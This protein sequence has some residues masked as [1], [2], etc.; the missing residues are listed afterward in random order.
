MN[1]SSPPIGARALRL[2]LALAVAACLLS[3]FC[4]SALG[5]PTTGQFSPAPKDSLK[6]VGENHSVIV[7]WRSA[8]PADSVLMY[9]LEYKEV[10]TDVE[11]SWKRIEIRD[12]SVTTWTVGGLTNYHRYA[13]HLRVQYTN[14]K[15]SP[16]SGTVFATP[17][18]ATLSDL[19]VNTRTVTGFSPYTLTY[20]VAFPLGTVQTPTVTATTNDPTATAVVTNAGSLPGSATVVVTA[21]AT[22][23][24]T[25]RRTYTVNFTLAPPVT[26]S[27]DS[28]G[29]E[30]LD[31]ITR[32]SG[33][34]L[35]ELAAPNKADSAFL[36]WYT[37]DDTFEHAVAEDTIVT[38]NLTLHA[39][40]AALAAAPST[41]ED[42]FASAADR[43]PGFEI[44]VRSSDSMTAEAVK[45]ALRLEVLDD[46][47]FDGLSVTGGD[48]AF[49]VAAVGG[50]ARG[51]SYKLTLLDDALTFAGESDS[52][53]TY[54]FT[55]HKDE[56]MDLVLDPDVVILKSDKV[57]DMTVNGVKTSSPSIP[58][59][60]AGDTQGEGEIPEATETGTFTYE[61][62][63]P[64]AVGDVLAIYSGTPPDERVPT[65]DYSDED[66]AYVEVTGIDGATVT[67]Q[68]AEAEDVLFMPDVLPVERTADLDGNDANTSI[69]VPISLLTFTGTE[70][71]EM[72]LDAETKVE[73]GDYLAF[74]TGTL[75]SD[76][77]QIT[78]AVI[79]SVATSGADYI[80]A[81]DAVTE[82]QLAQA[83]ELYSSY[84]TDYQSALDAEEV[85][86]MEADIEQQTIDSGFADS[87][88][89]YLTTLALKTDGFRSQLRAAGLPEDVSLDDIAVEPNPKV[90]ARIYTDLEHF[91]GKNGL[92][93]E[94]TV[95]FSVTVGKSLMKID[96]SG[97]FKEEIRSSLSASGR[98]IWK[99][100]WFIPYISDY[101]ITG[102]FDLYNFTGIYITANL[103]TPSS[104]D[105]ID[106]A[107][108][109]KTMIEKKSFQT[110]EAEAKAQSFYERYDQMLDNTHDYVT[111]FQKRLHSEK[112][113]VDPMRVIAFRFSIDFVVNVDLNLSLGATFEYQ[114]ATRYVFALKLKGMTAT[115][116]QIELVDERYEVEFWV[117]GT[118]G[119]R[120]GLIFRIE[121]GL[122]TVD[123]ASVGIDIETGPYVRLWGYFYYHLLHENAQTTSTTSGS[124]YT[125]IGIYL[126]LRFY[127][128]AS[129]GKYEFN[130]TLYNHEF[131][132]WDTGNRM[133]IFNFSYVLTDATDDI[134]LKGNTTTYTLP[135]TVFS[136]K[137]MDLTK[138][139]ISVVPYT[140]GS[141]RFDITFSNSNFT[142]SNGV[143]TV[144]KPVGQEITEGTMTVKW[145]GGNLAFT[146]VAPSRTYH[147][148]WD[149]LADSYMIS[150]NSVNGS[151]VSPIVG[152]YASSVTLPAPTRA[153]YSFGGWYENA[154]YTGAAYTAT[155][156]PAR[157]VQLYA[158]WTATTNT[159]YTVR[160]YRQSL[161]GSYG[162]DPLLLET[163]PG[164]GTTDMQ[165]TPEVKSYTG[166]TAPQTRTMSIKGDGSTV[167][168]YYYARTSY[169]LTFS[170]QNG[171]PA[172]V[173]TV[174]YEGDMAAPAVVNTGWVFGGW[175]DNEA[176]AGDPNAATTMPAANVH[177]YAKWTATPEY[178]VK[179]YRQ[180]VDGSAYDLGAIQTFAGTPGA[181]VTP[182]VNSY[183]GFT[184]PAPQTVTIAGDGS[185]LV[186]YYYA[187]NSYKLTFK[188]QNGDEDVV[189]T[190]AY[191]AAIDAPAVTWT[192]HT[193]AGWYDSESFS[194][195]PYAGT[196][197]PAA[198]LQLYAKWTVNPLYRVRHYRQTVDGSAYDLI[199]TQ[200][201]RAAPGASVTPAVNTYAG[202][203]SPEPQTVTIAE[204]G[205]TVVEYHYARNSY[206]LTFKPQN[207]D[208]DIV[209]MVP[210]GTAI[211]GARVRWADHVFT[212]WYSDEGLTSP[213]TFGTMATQPLTLYAGWVPS[214][215]LPLVI[216]TTLSS[217]V[218]ATVPGPWVHATITMTW[219][220]PA[221]VVP[222]GTIRVT[223]F[224][225]DGHSWVVAERA[226]TAT[227][228]SPFSFVTTDQGL[229]RGE[230]WYGG[231]LGPGS[232]QFRAEYI[233]DAS[234]TFVGAASEWERVTTQ[235][236]WTET[237]DVPADMPGKTLPSSRIAGTL[238]SGDLADL[239]TIVLDPGDRIIM[240]LS[241]GANMYYA[242]L[243]LRQA[244]GAWIDE[245]DWPD[246]N[247]LIDYTVPLG[248][249]QATYLVRMEHLTSYSVPATYD[250][251]CRIIKG[252]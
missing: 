85:A 188:P 184:S 225:P 65:E 64:L 86:A 178:R 246:R 93:C 137:Q 164:S 120:A 190:V 140:Y 208:A 10:Q 192:N 232:Y 130:P 20:D 215:S 91:A 206:K 217:G 172:I 47:P 58:L 61:E 90:E 209:S 23:D 17:A 77:S 53:R 151:L 117:M 41:D 229:G 34:A 35:G 110:D 45:D 221:G 42:V 59:M 69:T 180:T 4:V 200:T 28:N 31:P 186:E 233:P 92:G 50:Y 179:H 149:N 73:A 116:D 72:G 216:T 219:N 24:T 46:T 195:Q 19:R 89:D 156:M 95:T 204:D 133:N 57:S 248:T 196:T 202:F 165:V 175:Y 96:L 227:A 157:N 3:V 154:E 33:E 230:A 84:E 114:K 245:T 5:A 15:W 147:V 141:G 56:V 211:E 145:L 74:Y 68:T 43:A 127:A 79:T 30:P 122:F 185:T 207:G 236:S 167:V 51:A 13:F 40:W 249:A 106:I 115:T 9:V 146:S 228:T 52:V 250:F 44:Q 231:V 107:K 12:R 174:L 197:M 54:C 108:E 210:H 251:T 78:F 223:G 88:A 160:H 101:Q 181:S 218:D 224:M 118:L 99:W 198:D 136:M 29:G 48:G 171:D 7:T 103:T 222:T 123:M 191:G 38:S 126:H 81:Y 155:S 26:V 109:I 49:T 27:F 18:D 87:A 148:V 105:P 220:A 152:A 39:R 36:G 193:F 134:H 212:G 98:A 70:F 37:D 14:L 170:P 104:P 71:A 125:E 83:M 111:L 247:R 158:K 234:S 129:K 169:Q 205:S 102:N 252:N 131:P 150:F 139:D 75:G 189:S 128:Q 177:L 94:I 100:K 214:A 243:E 201:L 203:A 240:A 159:A 182:A 138:G 226:V 142:Q 183:A 113:A 80:I 25:V 112:G 82:D 1:T 187:R 21:K 67:Y 119:V 153:G 121:F 55:I 239:F 235:G 6:A 241:G 162:D 76:A 132:L 63:D 173:K 168:D 11:D 62:A 244:D 60:T 2:L 238:A 97:T 194:G 163:Q 8:A 166:F 16:Y 213:Y 199:A 143:I 144:Q 176:C 66:V 22:K 32:N 161:T 237:T 124:L 242:Q 135:S